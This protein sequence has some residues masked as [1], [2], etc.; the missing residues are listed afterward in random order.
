MTW[1]IAGLLQATVSHEN[2][3]NQLPCTAG[4]LVA[5]FRVRR[6]AVGLVIQCLG[7]PACVQ[8]HLQQAR[9]ITVTIVRPRTFKDSEQRRLA[10]VLIQETFAMVG[11]NPVIHC[12]AG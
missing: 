11:I 8:Q 9:I 6:E 5:T 2:I 12:A 4:A 7:M 3:P 10:V 1:S